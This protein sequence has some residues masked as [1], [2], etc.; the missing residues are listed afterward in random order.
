MRG[1]LV[2]AYTM[3]RWV[4]RKGRIAGL[5]AAAT[6]ALSGC[7]SL[8]VEVPESLLTLSPEA[9]AAVGSGAAVSGA[10]SDRAIAVLTPEVPAK[11]DVLRVPVNVSATKIAYLEDVLG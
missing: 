6:L 4:T 3:T 10:A 7:V 9:T 1:G 8:G 11:L 2:K 5:A